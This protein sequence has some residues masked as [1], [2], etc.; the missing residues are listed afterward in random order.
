[1]GTPYEL[2]KEIVG[3]RTTLAAAGPRYQAP[4]AEIARGAW[5]W[6]GRRG[7]DEY[8]HTGM[9]LNLPPLF[10]RMSNDRASP[11]AGARHGD[12]VG[13]QL[14]GHRPGRAGRA[15]HAPCC[16]PVRLRRFAPGAGGAPAAPSVPAPG[17]VHPDHVRAAVRAAV[18]RDPARPLPSW[19]LGE[20]LAAWK[21]AAATLVLAGLALNQWAANGRGRGESFC[22][23]CCKIHPGPAD[24]TGKRR[25]TLGQERTWISSGRQ[26]KGLV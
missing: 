26:G 8:D 6:D 13:A 7:F 21:A 22:N 1:M 9:E 20:P 24:E 5:A 2:D 4:L 19:E 16:A 15:A 12:G 10:P 23:V 17:P 18:H 11:S 14:R 3:R 25:V